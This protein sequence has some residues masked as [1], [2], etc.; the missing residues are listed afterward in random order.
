MQHKNLVYYINKRLIRVV[1]WFHV[2]Q[3]H[4]QIFVKFLSFNNLVYLEAFGKN[5]IS[6]YQPIIS[7]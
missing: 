6:Q 3:L 1:K 2:Y 5:Y 7:K 4:V